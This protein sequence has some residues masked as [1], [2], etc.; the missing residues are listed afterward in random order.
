[1]A[2]IANDFQ[3]IC[4]LPGVLGAIDGT[5]FHIAKPRYG[6]SDYFYFKSRGYTMNCQAV[7]DS[8]KRFLNLY[9][10][11]PGSTNDS[12]MLRRSALFHRGQHRTLWN[13]TLAFNG[14]SPYLL[15][16]SGYPLLPWLMIPHRRDNNI[17]VS[18]ALFNRKLSRGRSVVENAF[19]LLKLTFRELHGKCNLD[20]CFVPDVVVC[21]A[22][23]HNIL[24]KDSDEEIARLLE[25]IHMQNGRDEDTD[26]VN[27]ED[28]FSETEVEDVEPEEA[29]AKRSDLGAFLSIQR[30]FRD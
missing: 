26:E 10:G 5:H 13:P 23:L 1:L 9:V 21:C 27:V 4:G 25:I 14:F 24:L 2:N 28:D 12:R 3:R 15:G 7:V 11:M 18:G 17:S 19:A 22:I 6:A 8:S 29:R 20:V 30:I 16:D